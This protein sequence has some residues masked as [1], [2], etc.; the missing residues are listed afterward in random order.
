MQLP[1][2]LFILSSVIWNAGCSRSPQLS[3]GTPLS[4]PLPAASACLSDGPSDPNASPQAAA[5]YRN[6]KLLSGRA[7][8]FGHHETLA[9]GIGWRNHNWDSDIARVCGDYPAVFGWD[10]GEIGRPANIDHV[11]F[12]RMKN[13]IRQVYEKNGINTISWHMRN[14]ATGGSSWDTTPAVSRLLPGG[15][16]HETYRRTL[17]LAAAF[18]DIRGPNNEPIPIVLR[19]FHEHNGDWFWWGR[20]TCTPEEFIRLWRFTVDYFRNEKQMHQFL[21]AYSPDI[22]K[23]P[24]DYLERY[25]GDKYV[26]ILGMDNY[27][28]FRNGEVLE[29]AVRD[30]QLL[31]RIAAEK[32]KPAALTETGVNKMPDPNWFTQVLLQ[33]MT[34]DES[35]R[36]IVWVCLWRNESPR[37]FFAVYPEH[38]AAEDFRAFY[39]H[40]FTLFLS[41]MPE[42]YR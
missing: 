38:P 36:R 24:Q 26:D 25:P 32:N 40:P 34:A 5:L 30:L 39:A 7:V 3:E 19:L 35:T 17:E 14:P 23:S 16:L 27:Y 12:D 42:M 10:L 8:L 21:Y 6:L 33:A 9:Y 28:H 13:W 15:D 22:C 1:A 41:E 4:H 31:A 29:Q 37:H 20:K 2:F 11:P 18:L